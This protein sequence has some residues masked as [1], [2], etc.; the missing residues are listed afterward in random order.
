APVADIASNFEISRASDLDVEWD[1]G[2]EG[3][4]SVSL[5]GVTDEE[6]T[7]VSCMVPSADGSVTVDASLLEALPDT[8][9][10]SVSA[11]ASAT[12]DIGDDWM[13]SFSG[14]NLGA[15]GTTTITD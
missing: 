7:T 6:A 14:T 9:A 1:G 2:G 11:T 13:V 3:M 8:G 4:V 12:S 15:S 5:S 10:M